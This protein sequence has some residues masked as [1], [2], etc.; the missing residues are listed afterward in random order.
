MFE[1]RPRKVHFHHDQQGAT[2][3]LKM[4][5]LQRQREVEKEQ[6]ASDRY[7]NAYYR[8]QGSRREAPSGVDRAA[9]DAGQATGSTVGLDAQVG[10]ETRKT[11]K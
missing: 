10:A 11:L 8:R 5:P 4:T 9:Y 6:R 1:E 7:W 3:G 2:F